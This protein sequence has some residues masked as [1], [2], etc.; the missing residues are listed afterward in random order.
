MDTAKTV[1]SVVVGV[2][3]TTGAP[4]TAAP[5]P[6]AT[7]LLIV[8][9]SVGEIAEPAPVTLA[10]GRVVGSVIPVAPAEAGVPVIETVTT[11]ALERVVVP[12][13]SP[14][15]KPDTLKSDVVMDAS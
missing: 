13:A 3:L 1:I 8:V 14:V 7:V 4:L 2:P 6:F 12:V 15:G 5:A 10:A 11:V 9:A